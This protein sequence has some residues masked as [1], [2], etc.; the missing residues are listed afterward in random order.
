MPLDL[1]DDVFLLDLA[2]ESA[3]RTFKRFAVL[4]QYFGQSEL[5][6]LT[7]TFIIN[8]SHRKPPLSA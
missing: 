2:F 1:F 7:S 8:D 5:T 4:D 3:Q 6:P